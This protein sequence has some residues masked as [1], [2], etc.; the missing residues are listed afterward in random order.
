MPLKD[1]LI[2]LGF[3]FTI[4]PAERYALRSQEETS[5]YSRRGQKNIAVVMLQRP[6]HWAMAESIATKRELKSSRRSKTQLS[7]SSFGSYRPT[8]MPTSVNKNS[9]GLMVSANATN[10]PYHRWTGIRSCFPNARELWF[11][12]KTGAAVLSLAQR[13]LLLL[14]LLGLDPNHL[15]RFPRTIK[16]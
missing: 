13:P 6:H 1:P 12:Y 10:R 7:K 8:S 4:L 15:C 2:T 11:N 9:L 3:L 5:F 14:S 16:S